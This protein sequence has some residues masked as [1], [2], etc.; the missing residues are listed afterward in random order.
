MTHLKHVGADVRGRVQQWGPAAVR[1]SM[2]V[3]FYGSLV[4]SVPR[5]SGGLA[6]THTRAHTHCC[7][8]G[9][10]CS[11]AAGVATTIGGGSA[12]DGS[13]CLSSAKRGVLQEVGVGVEARE[14]ICCVDLDPPSELRLFVTINVTFYSILQTEFNVSMINVYFFEIFFVCSGRRKETMTP[15]KRLTEQ[16]NVCLSKMDISNAQC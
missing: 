10:C 8:G 2:C 6:I 11:G 1:S 13:R 3:S 16:T 15:L 9:G 4:G 14:V 7:V 12:V 5:G